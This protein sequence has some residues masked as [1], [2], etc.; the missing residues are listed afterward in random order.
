MCSIACDEP[1]E[2][3]PSA[4]C[5]MGITAHQ[6]AMPAQY[7]GAAGAISCTFCPPAVVTAVSQGEHSVLHR[8][9]SVQAVI[10]SLE[11]ELRLL[12]AR[13]AELL[14]KAQSQDCSAWASAEVC[15]PCQARLV[16]CLMQCGCCTSALPSCWP[17]FSHRTALHGP[18]PTSALALSGRSVRSL[19]SSLEQRVAVQAKRDALAQMTAQVLDAMHQKGAQIRQLQLHTPTLQAALV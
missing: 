3:G 9:E 7:G 4:L 2:T 12:D 6:L 13:F 5:H 19:Q 1:C 15:K 14:A 17:K 8:R 18:V 11:D 16:P 10:V